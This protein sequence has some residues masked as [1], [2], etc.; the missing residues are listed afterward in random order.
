MAPESPDV[1]EVHLRT[2]DQLFNSLDPLPFH[3][4]DLDEKAERY[5]TGWAREIKGS[6]AH[7]AQTYDCAIR[8]LA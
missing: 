8:P 2:V 3:K 6:G 5:I 7:P 1:I 4:P